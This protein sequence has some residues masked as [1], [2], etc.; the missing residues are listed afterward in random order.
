MSNITYQ[1]KKT[2]NDT[3]KSL[4]YRTTQIFSSRQS[5]EYVQMRRNVAIKLR[6]EGWGTARIARVL[7][8]AFGTVK[9]YLKDL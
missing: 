9:N 4:G 1:D 5:E 6:K 3:I 7:D 8:L 2:L